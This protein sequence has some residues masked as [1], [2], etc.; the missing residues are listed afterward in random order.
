MEYNFEVIKDEDFNAD[1]II[2]YPK[3]M[4]L[5]VKKKHESVFN[6]IFTK[7]NV[8]GSKNIGYV[9]GMCKK[10]NVKSFNDFLERVY[11]N[12]SLNNYNSSLRGK[13]KKEIYDIVCSM[14]EYAKKC[15]IGDIPLH[16]FYIYFLDVAFNRTTDGFFHEY[17]F[18][19]EAE[20]SGKYKVI[21][22]KTA[23]DDE[24]KGIDSILEAISE[25]A[26][27]HA[28]QLKP[29]TFVKGNYNYGLRET[30]KSF[31]KKSK[32]CK[33]PFYMYFY[34][35]DDGYVINSNADETY[36]NVCCF[37]VE[38]LFDENGFVKSIYENGVYTNPIDNEK[39]VDKIPF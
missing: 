35:E 17:S 3:S 9:M 19:K 10:Y 37:R 21:E 34:K 13:T 18:N 1:K 30:R 20:E 23:Y 5:E 24:Y 26:I 11:T 29:F 8:F 14:K 36:P 27:T 33:Y 39:V 31:F 25:N 4:I 2:A 28:V 16:I 32:Q 22:T 38:E 12:E 15:G 7:M 6:P